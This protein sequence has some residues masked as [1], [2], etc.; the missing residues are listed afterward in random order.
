M[1]VLFATALGAALST[2]AL[3]ARAQD[4]RT[5]PANA[6]PPP[7]TR[8]DDVSRS[9]PYW[10]AGPYRPFVAGSFKT[11]GIG[12]DTEIAVGFGKPHYL[13]AGLELDT[14][15][16]LRGAT[17][18]LG[19]KVGTPWA[20][21]RFGPRYFTAFSQR[22]IAE[23]KGPVTRAALDVDEAP[24]THYL[25]ID[26]EAA[27]QIP[28]PASGSLGLVLTANDVM[29]VQEG[30]WVFEDSLRVV[31]EP[32]FV[33]RARLS[34]LTGV[35]LYDTL[36]VG[37]V[38][39]VLGNPGRDYVNVRLGPAVTVALTHHLEAYGVAVLSVFNPDEIGLAGADLGQIGLRY[40][41]AT[42]DL[43]PDFP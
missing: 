36:Y 42:G 11:G 25:S 27:F 22:L 20:T 12:I 19:V 23:T 40:R 13:W 14:G 10:S 32:G 15:L 38:I 30:Y 7:G 17:E 2:A 39:E 5:L 33:G 18:W 26:A 8:T 1:R 34:Y 29:F 35:G 9:G 28:L 21:I 41:W 24:R 4:F 6:T 43:W 16:S 37:G 3:S 31:V